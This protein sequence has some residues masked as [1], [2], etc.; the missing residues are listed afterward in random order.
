V[1]IKLHG[2]GPAA[3]LLQDLV[4]HRGKGTARVSQTFRDIAQYYGTDKQHLIKK[5]FRR[6]M[7]IGGIRYASLGNKWSS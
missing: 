7:E 6:R 2:R 1:P 5:K 3:Y 4:C